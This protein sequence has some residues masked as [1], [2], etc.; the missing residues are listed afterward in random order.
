MEFAGYT[1]DTLKALEIPL[2][3]SIAELM[4]VNVMQVVLTFPSTRLKERKQRVLAGEVEV[5]VT[6]TG[7]EGPDRQAEVMAA[8]ELLKT[9]A[10][11]RT[12]FRDLFTAEVVGDDMSAEVPAAFALE[13]V[14]EATVIPMTQA[15][16]IFPTGVPT[17]APTHEEG[18]PFGQFMGVCIWLG[19]SVGSLVVVAGL[20]LFVF[21]LKQRKLA[22]RN[23]DAQMTAEAKIAIPVGFSI[24][25]PMTANGRGGLG[26]NLQLKRSHFDDNGSDGS[27]QKDRAESVQAAGV[28]PSTGATYYRN[29]VTDKTAWTANEASRSFVEKDAAPQDLRT[30]RTLRTESV[31]EL[32][33]SGT[34]TTYFH[35]TITGKTAWTAE[36]AS[37]QSEQK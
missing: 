21:K 36:E 16:T 7:I 9:D 18:C 12:N 29:T 35:N 5:V 14:G 32:A 17:M 3:R 15:P 2:K 37:R 19:A 31:Q 26:G 8:Q 23:A 24:E 22:R 11:A 4:G 34:G 28:D 1:S 25:N 6:I 13:T 20:V 27:V 30:E 10:S 33:E